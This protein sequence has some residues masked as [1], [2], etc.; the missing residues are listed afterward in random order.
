MKQPDPKKAF[1]R[2]RVLFVVIDRPEDGPLAFHQSNLR[3]VR[4]AV[5][6]HDPEYEVVPI[7]IGE[8]AGMDEAA[9][10]ATYHPLCIFSAGSFTEWFLYGVDASW[11]A[12][13]DHY[14]T[15]LRRTTMPVLAVCGSHQLVAIAFN[16]FSAVAHMTDAG[17]PV[18][19]S[20]ELAA[21]KPR[22]MWPTPRVGEEGTYPVLA[23]Q[24]GAMDPI[25]KAAGT[26]PLVASHHKDMVVDITGFTLL[27]TGDEGRSPATL[28]G[29][30]VKVRCRVQGVRLDDATRVLYA[31][32]FHPEMRQFDESTSDD[33]GFGAK[34]IRAF[35]SAA[36]RHW[37]PEKT[38]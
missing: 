3:G 1:A 33:Q 10:E 16:G 29:E 4:S 21:P 38:V 37:S 20:D 32:Q 14:M 34:W 26:T 35:L 11:R 25:V 27:Y 28:A 9:I 36:E 18:R 2:R 12:S 8:L 13:L 24:A 6:S 22:G 23:T 31:T 7:T 5:S 30:Q 15:F 19:I 17:A